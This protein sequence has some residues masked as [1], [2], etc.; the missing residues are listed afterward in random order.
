[1]NVHMRLTLIVGAMLL[2]AACSAPE[3]ASPVA[4]PPTAAPTE[5]A[6]LTPA[7]VLANMTERFNAGDLDGGMV[8]WADDA[9]WYILG[10]PPTGTELLVGK[11]AIRAE[12]ERELAD[13][14]VWNVA[15]SAVTGTEVRSRDTTWLDFTRQ[16]GV[17]PIEATGQY[18]VEDGL[19]RS[20]AWTI[21][22]AALVRLKAALAE[23]APAEEGDS[24]ESMPT[25]GGATAPVSAVAVTI[26]DGMCRLDQPV[27][28]RQGPVTVT[29][30]VR[31]S[32]RRAYTVVFLTLDDGYDAAD[33]MASTAGNAPPSW[34][35]AR[36]WEEVPHSR[37]RSWTIEADGGP[38]FGVCLSKPPDHPI[39]LVG[40][41]TVTP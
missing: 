22:S 11:D 38:L 28:L 5:S 29:L 30:N 1:M 9:V 18:V 20:Y 41:L 4:P 24:A 31:D 13:H 26:A 14:L 27:V 40:P 10:L 33:L 16:L 3:P 37:S 19:V 39:G 17:A 23:L 21:D 6:A 34:A 2:L 8:Y 7:D 35:H 32:N 25:E 36:H 15:V 12:F